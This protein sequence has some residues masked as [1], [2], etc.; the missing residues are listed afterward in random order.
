MVLILDSLDGQRVFEELSKLV[1]TQGNNPQ[2]N[3]TTIYFRRV[4]PEVP[5]NNNPNNQTNIFLDNNNNYL[6]S[7]SSC[8]PTFISTLINETISCY[9]D[10][11]RDIN[12]LDMNLARRES[13]VHCFK[14]IKGD[15]TNIIAKNKLL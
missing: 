10:N 14:S 12:N 7:R 15:I 11:S 3:F 2:L 13:S 8:E 6:K 9:D 5:N 1:S 4:Q